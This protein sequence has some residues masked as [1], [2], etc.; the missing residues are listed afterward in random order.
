MFMHALRIAQLI[1]AALF[2]LTQQLFAQD[3]ARVIHLWQNVAPGFEDRKNEPE[4]AKEYWVKNVHNPSVSVFLPPKGK[5]NGAAV[6]I[7]PGG[8]HRLLVHGAEGV[9]PAKFLNELG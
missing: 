5:S 4:E 9:E 2:I 8:G 1:V 6:I 3:S 7:C